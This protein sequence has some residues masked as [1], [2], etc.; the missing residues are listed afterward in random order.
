MTPADHLRA[1][2]SL[3]GDATPG[4]RAR[5]RLLLRDVEREAMMR[6][7]LRDGRAREAIESDSGGV[8]CSRP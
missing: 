3:M 8:T 2:L 6:P 1:A 5:V 7:P 4:L